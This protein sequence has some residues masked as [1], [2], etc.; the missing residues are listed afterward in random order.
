MRLLKRL[1]HVKQFPLVKQDRKTTIMTGKKAGELSFN[2][3]K[4]WE[5]IVN[6]YLV[7]CCSYFLKAKSEL[8]DKVIGLIK[9]C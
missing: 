3:V 1:I 2:G 4:F 6:D 7:Y 9:M 8:K 5:P